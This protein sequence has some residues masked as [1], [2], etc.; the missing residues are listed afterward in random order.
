MSTSI[1]YNSVISKLEA[2]SAIPT[3][4]TYKIFEE[5]QEGFPSHCVG[6]VKAH[7]FIL[8]LASQAFMAEFN[9]LV[10]GV[11]G[12]VVEGPKSPSHIVVNMT[13]LEAFQKMVDYIYR[14]PLHLET[15]SLTSIFHMADLA[16][17]YGLPQLRN[18]LVHHVQSIG[19]TR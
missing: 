11:E 1:D 19:F 8:G 2:S 4:I 5:K 13:T 18:C 6:E 3:D 17:R 16:R 10:E 14:K 15:A 9:G 12:V 7:R